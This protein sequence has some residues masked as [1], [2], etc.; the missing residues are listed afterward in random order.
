MKLSES[1]KIAIIV[2]FLLAWALALLLLVFYKEG[3]FAPKQVFPAVIAPAIALTPDLTEPPSTATPTL[4]PTSTPTPM[5]TATVAFTWYV[6]Q[7]GDSLGALADRFGA[8]L[9]WMLINN[10][11]EDPRRVI[12]VGQRLK[13]P[14]VPMPTRTPMPLCNT[15]YEGGANCRSDHDWVCG[16]W[17]AMLLY[18]SCLETRP[19]DRRA[20]AMSLQECGGRTWRPTRVIGVHD[21]GMSE[22]FSQENS[23]QPQMPSISPPTEDPPRASDGPCVPSIEWFNKNEA[24]DHCG[25]ASAGG[26]EIPMLVRFDRGTKICDVERDEN[27]R[28]SYE[29]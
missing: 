20:V 23:Q 10:R 24:G 14:L 17:E 2:V 7:P 25:C 12:Y 22:S 21:T 29:R 19:H 15:C 3:Y 1:T 13:V 27:G 4:E 9:S 6:V 26:I 5:P 18:P 11:I 16:Y 28:I 8:S